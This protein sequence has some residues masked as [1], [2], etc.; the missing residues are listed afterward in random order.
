LEILNLSSTAQPGPKNALAW[1]SLAPGLFVLLWASGFVVGKLGLPYA[2]PFTILLLRFAIAT[3][4]MVAVSFL[5]RAN[6]PKTRIQAF[7]VAVVGVLLQAVYLGGCYVAM[8]E[9]IPAGVTALIVGLQPLL[10]ATLVGPLL[11]E[12]VSPRQWL[13]LAIGFAGVTLV[14]WNKLHFDSLHLGGILYAFGGLLGITAATN[15]IGIITLPNGRHLAIAVFVSDSPTDE[16]T[17][18]GV[19]ARIAK[20]IWDKLG[21]E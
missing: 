2:R 4:F 16:V 13:G 21:N 19:I 20:A 10:T 15:D 9:G 5:T 3:V 8:A 17:R 18:E 11:T 1:Q 12:R 6:W 7:H 14:L